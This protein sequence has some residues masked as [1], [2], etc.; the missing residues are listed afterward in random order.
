MASRSDAH[1]TLLLLFM[2]DSVPPAFLFENAKNMIQG[3][4]YQKLKDAACQLKPERESSAVMVQST[5][6]LVE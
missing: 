2:Q 6:I 1:E 3:K 4:F 5:K